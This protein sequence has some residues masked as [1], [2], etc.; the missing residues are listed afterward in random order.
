MKYAHITNLIRCSL[1]N[2]I[3]VEGFIA[4]EGDF[5]IDVDLDVAPPYSSTPNQ[6]IGSKMITSF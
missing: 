2:I 4:S 1:I 5:Y 6:V 3:T